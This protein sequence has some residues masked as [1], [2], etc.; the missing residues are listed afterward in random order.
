MNI[1]NL[2]L[3]M[4]TKLLNNTQAAHLIGVEPGTVGAWLNGRRK[5]SRKYADRISEL[6]KPVI[7]FTPEPGEQIAL[8]D[9]LIKAQNELIEMLKDRIEDLEYQLFVVRSK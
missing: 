5:I 4:N 3:L 6:L 8:Y 2:N 9:N 7:E 1:E